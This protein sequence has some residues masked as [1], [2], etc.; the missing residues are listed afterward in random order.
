MEALQY[1]LKPFH[2]I[3]KNLEP[4]SVKSG[5]TENILFVSSP[6][7]AD[8]SATVQRNMIASYKNA[9]TA[10]VV[11]KVAYDAATD[12][13]FKLRYPATSQAK[14]AIFMRWLLPLKTFNK[15]M[16]NSMEKV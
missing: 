2:I 6:E 8:Y 5:F 14:F 15:L 1:E 12:N 10:D 7:Y 9:P 11:A 13:K 4:A 16:A 3:V